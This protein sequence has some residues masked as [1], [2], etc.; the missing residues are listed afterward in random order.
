MSVRARRLLL[1][2]AT[3]T[4][5]GCPRERPT[6]PQPVEKEMM[7]AAPAAPKFTGKLPPFSKAMGKAPSISPAMGGA[8]AGSLEWHKSELPTMEISI[9]QSARGLATVSF[10]DDGVADGCFVSR[11]SHHYARSKY[12]SGGASSS[13]DKRRTFV[14]ARG[15]WARG[16]DGW[17]DVHFDEVTRDAC[18]PPK[19][20]DPSK[21]YGA[22]DLHCIRVEANEA[23]PIPVLACTTGDVDWPVRDLGIDI[24]ESKPTRW[25]VLADA[26]S[27]IAVRAIQER[28][29]T[30]PKI[31]F[32]KQP[33]TLTPSMWVKDD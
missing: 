5:I 31:T 11:W 20:L 16:N 29:E 4:S 14:G 13:T 15:R 33:V 8:Y 12:T 17:L 26:A 27:G 22:F 7:D 9:D 10:G 25:I 6:A 19:P 32:E 24:A 23:L 3:T 30:E 1:A 28:R 2:L 18:A 21:S